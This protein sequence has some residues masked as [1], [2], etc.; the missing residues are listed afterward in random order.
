MLWE[1][2]HGAPKRTAVVCELLRDSAARVRLPPHANPAD[3]PRLDAN[4]ALLLVNGAL[5]ALGAHVPCTQADIEAAFQHLTDPLVGEAVYVDAAQ[6]AIV[7]R[8]IR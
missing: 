8:R 3:A 2:T 6:N 5:T 4:A 7:F 1:R